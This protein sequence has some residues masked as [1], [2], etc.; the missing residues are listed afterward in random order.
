M[1]SKLYKNENNE[2]EVQLKLSGREFNT[3]FT[4]FGISSHSERQ[5]DSVETGIEILESKEAENFYDKC[6]DLSKDIITKNYNSVPQESVESVKPLTHSY[7]KFA[8]RPRVTFNEALAHYENG[9]AVQCRLLDENG[10][11][12]EVEEYHKNLGL[13]IALEFNEILHGHWFLY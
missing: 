12:V 10:Y 3:L 2:L 6:V 7:Y 1:Q 11:V 8:P 9:G 13:E 4:A 5:E